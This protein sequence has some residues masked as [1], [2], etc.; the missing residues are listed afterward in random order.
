MAAVQYM[1]GLSTVVLFPVVTGFRGP[2]NL[3]VLLGRL[4]AMQANQ[5]VC[6]YGHASAVLATFSM[7]AS[8]AAAVVPGGAGATAASARLPPVSARLGR[9]P[10]PLVC[11]RARA[12]SCQRSLASLRWPARSRCRAR[13]PRRRAPPGRGGAPGVRAAVPQRA[14]LRRRQHPAAAD[15]DGLPA[16]RAHRSAAGRSRRPRPAHG[17]DV[18]HHPG[19]HSLWRADAQHAG[20]VRFAAPRA[21]AGV[22]FSVAIFAAC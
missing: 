9:H 6:D 14:Q 12:S 10:A 3:H 4:S 19:H 17:R 18:H 5:P 8:H 13:G 22:T 15:R 1:P 16:L 11:A 21:D 7:G 2:N 20:P